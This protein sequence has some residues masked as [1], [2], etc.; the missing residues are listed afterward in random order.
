MALMYLQSMLML[1]LQLRLLPQ[2]TCLKFCAVTDPALEVLPPSLQ[3]PALLRRPHPPTIVPFPL[4]AAN[5][6]HGNTINPVSAS[7]YFLPVTEKEA[8]STLSSESHTQVA[9]SAVSLVD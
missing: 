4:G 2:V 1:L 8:T 6:T 9:G 7:S 5:N 3:S